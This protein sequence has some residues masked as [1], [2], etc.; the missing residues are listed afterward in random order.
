MMPE[1]NNEIMKD[2]GRS[3][4]KQRLMRPSQVSSTLKHARCFQKALKARPSAASQ[5]ATSADMLLS[6]Y[7]DY[8]GL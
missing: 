8:G 2:A 4:Q 3:A 1:D 6:S 7:F 5:F